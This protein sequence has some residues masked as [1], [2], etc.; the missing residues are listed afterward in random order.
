MSL[1]SVGGNAG[2]ALAPVL[3]TPLALAFGPA[4]VAWLLLLPLVVGVAL[5]LEL[6]RL[7]GFRPGPI[8]ASAVRG[9]GKGP[10]GAAEERWGPFVR[11]AGLA[12]WRSGVYFGL[13]TF[14]A[15]YFIHRYGA[16]EAEANVALT[17]VLAAG[18]IGTLVGGRV[19][20][21]IGRRPVLV[22]CMAVLTPLLVL[23]MFSGQL[24]AYVLLTLVGFFTVGNFSVTVVLGQEYL[25]GR[26]GVSSGITL[27][28]A[29]GA[30]G[31][32]ASA[33]GVLADHAGLQAVMWTVALMP[34]PALLLALSL[35]RE[36]L[37]QPETRR[38]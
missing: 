13:Q 14:V 26:I 10:G 38:L 25:P 29:I 20:D 15:A 35:P 7:N 36:D 19:A 3:V 11:V 6:P 9:A 27:G 1:F 8:P 5:A 32:V 4:G 33:L 21:R 24:A 28:A 31:L 16:S 22:G 23:V 34:I 12:A 18:V 37:R 30:G 2:F 17:V